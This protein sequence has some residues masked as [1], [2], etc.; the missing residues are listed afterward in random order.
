MVVGITATGNGSPASWGDSIVGS[1]YTINSIDD[2]RADTSIRICTGNLATQTAN[3]YF[4]DNPVVT[5]RS[6]DI[7]ECYEDMRDGLAD[8]FL[9]SLPVIPTAAQMGVAGGPA[10][11]PSV[12]TKIV[13]GTPYWVQEDDVECSA[14]A[15]PPFPPSPLGTFRECVKD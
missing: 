15:S 4:P 5:K 12:D 2:L 11:Q 6:Y 14:V 7:A 1:P 9:N 8:V 13:A 3:Q 10:M